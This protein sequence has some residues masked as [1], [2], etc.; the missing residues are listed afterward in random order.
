MSLIDWSIVWVFVIFLIY[1]AVS[2]AKYNKGVADFLSANRCAGRYLL[3][4]GEGTAG[5]GAIS[6]V[7]IFENT[8]AAG[9][10][11][12]YWSNVAIPI[13]LFIA[14]SGWIIYRYRQ[15]RAMT[16]SQFFEMR[17]SKKFRIFSGILAWFAG[18]VNFGIFP[19]IGARFFVS[20][21]GLP[22]QISLAGIEIMTL[23][24]IMFVLLCISLLFTF[25]GGQISIIITEFWQGMFTLLVF[26]VLILFIWFTFSWGQIGE[27]LKTASTPGV[28][29]IDPFD[30]SQAKDFNIW[31][32][33]IMWF[34]AL[35]QAMAW[36]GNQAYNCSAATPHEAKMAKVVGGFRMNMI[37]LGLLLIPLMA[38]TV[39]NH[40]SYADK[41]A[42]VTR[43]LK[44]AFPGDEVLQKEMVVPITLRHVL[45][46]GLL[47]AFAAAMLAFFIS[48]HCTYLHS[49]GSIFI[50]DV[51][52][53]LRNRPISPQRHMWYLRLS[54]I[55]VAVFIFFFSLLV[56][57]KDYILMFLT[58][59]GG[60]YL[61]GAGAVII[62]GLYWK[63]GT[64]AGAWSAMIVGACISVV[65]LILQQV[66]T[67]IP[68]LQSISKEFPFNGVMVGFFAAVAGIIAYVSVS[69]IGKKSI[70]DFDRILHRGQYAVKEEEQ[71][72]EESASHEKVGRFW[73]MLGVNNR[74]FSKVDK[75]IFLFYFLVSMWGVGYFLV[76]L[77][78]H[79]MGYMK[80][81]NS[82]IAWWK[83]T[84]LVAMV[85]SFSGAVWIVI[86]G[87]VDLKKM[88]KRLA[89]MKRNDLDDGRVMGGQNLADVVTL[90]DNSS[91]NTSDEFQIK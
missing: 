47:G 73:K 14:F 61:G 1:R 87:F 19:A 8:Y 66:W 4:V 12:S 70:A 56:P 75:G 84:I 58:I 53:P 48:N 64:T 49:W 25:S 30:I 34:F 68:I 83:I 59:T 18:V 72:T 29:M 51:I 77:L 41:A 69:L 90:A 60:I 65:G 45:P 89:V 31:F 27:A 28:S 44:E 16:M 79:L 15:T 2:S 11:P 67:S 50:Q 24:L 13:S 80:D 23:P 55:G 88:Y 81:D 63:R 10:A 20:Y 22:Q 21:C 62:G 52:Q 17:Y 43:Q 33:M 39:M 71:E 46:T 7:L 37:Y 54:I 78:L 36:Q 85:I 26:A 5:M 57:M 74:E 91:I 6:V 42:A 3:G 35:Y 9:L 32:Y 76:L 38:I 40:P 86:G 82:W